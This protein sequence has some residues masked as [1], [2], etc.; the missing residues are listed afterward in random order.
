MSWLRDDGGR[1]TIHTRPIVTE[2]ECGASEAATTWRHRLD[3]GMYVRDSAGLE[4]GQIKGI[5]SGS[6]LVDRPDGGPLSLPYERIHAIVSDRVRLDVSAA[7]LDA[8]ATRGS[9]FADT[10]DAGTGA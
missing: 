10:P 1:D 5:D 3:V 2:A 6:F 4:V 8:A 7:E 9:S